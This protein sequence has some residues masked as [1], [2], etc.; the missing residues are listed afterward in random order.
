MLELEIPFQR[1]DVVL[2]CVIDLF[3][4]GVGEEGRQRL[5]V[6]QGEGVDQVIPSLRGE[7]DQ[8]DLLLVGVEAVGLGV[9]RQSMA[10]PQFG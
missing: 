2:G 4:V 7:L 5:Q 10:C 9:D 8:A 6:V 1:H 3:Q